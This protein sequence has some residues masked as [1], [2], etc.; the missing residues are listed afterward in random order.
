MSAFDDG[1]TSGDRTPTT[2]EMAYVRV[3]SNPAKVDFSK[4]PHG[5]KPRSS[6]LPRLGKDRS[7]EDR[8]PDESRLSVVPEEDERDD[9]VVP[10]DFVT[11][12]PKAPESVFDQAREESPAPAP[13]PPDINDEISAMFD[14]SPTAAPVEEDP[15]PSPARIA[16]NEVFDR[17]PVPGFRPKTLYR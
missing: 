16:E 2:Q 4:L 3:L 10:N 8:R 13:A 14:A 12:Q 9:A 11:M 17:K 15:N 7:D 6:E 5:R 1:S